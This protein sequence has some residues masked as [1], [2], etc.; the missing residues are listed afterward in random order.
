M[1]P[2]QGRQGVAQT[3]PFL[4]GGSGDVFELFR[5]G[6]T[7]SVC[8]RQGVDSKMQREQKDDCLSRP[9]SWCHTRRRR[10]PSGFRFLPSGS[11]LDEVGVGE[12]L[13]N[14]SEQNA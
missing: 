7:G 13:D 10:T 1:R 6:I 11:L 12:S 4:A 14:W 5:R 2:A 8:L 3:G 9:L